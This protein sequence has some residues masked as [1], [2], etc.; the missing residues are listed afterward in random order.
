MARKE[1]DLTACM[2]VQQLDKDFFTNWTDEELKA[3]ED[4]DPIAI[5]DVLFKK[6]QA[7]KM[8][9]EEIHTII[10][11]KDVREVWDNTVDRKSVV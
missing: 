9:I 1:N 7:Q 10:H 8:V 3:I 11:D 2:I 6:L 5:S 4:A